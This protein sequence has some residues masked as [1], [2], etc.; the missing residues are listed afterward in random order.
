MG[1]RSW[2]GR[3]WFSVKT[4]AIRG[5]FLTGK[6]SFVEAD[7]QATTSGV[8]EVVDEAGGSGGRRLLCHFEL[9]TRQPLTGSRGWDLFARRLREGAGRQ[10]VRLECGW[11]GHHFVI[12][13]LP[14]EG[15]EKPL[16]RAASYRS[17]WFSFMHS[18]FTGEASLSCP[19]CEQKGAAGVK[20]LTA[21]KA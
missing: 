15:G 21:T 3:L 10:A 12:E 17:R 18:D 5:R 11:C 9:N 8:S 13:L 1:G 19:H 7:I 14:R 2:L 16:G 20:F 6:A 4:L